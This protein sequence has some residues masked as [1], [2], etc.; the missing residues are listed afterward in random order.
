MKPIPEFVYHTPQDL[1]EALQLISEYVDSLP[2]AGGTDLIIELRNGARKT[3]HL[4]SL[5]QV[6]DLNYIK[7]ESGHIHIGATTKHT[8]IAS[9]KLIKNRASILSEAALQVGSNQIRNLGTVGGNLCNASPGA[10]TATPLLVLGAQAVISSKEGTR[11]VPLTDFF[12]GPKRNCLKHGELLTE[13][14]FPSPPEGSGGG[15]QKLGRRQGCTI[16]LINAAA[17]IEV[18]SGV[19]KEARVAVGACAP[20]PVRIPAV[21]SQLKGEMLDHDLIE[22]VSRACY[23]LVEPSQ[24]EHSRAS[25]EYRR[26]MSCVLMKRALMGALDN[27][28]R[29]MK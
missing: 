13:V 4:I 5:N 27:A 28:R 2:I 3:G 8:Q 22:E 25:E 24:R 6:K 18:E 10:D 20:T 1:S 26:E 11:T 7:E 12:T 29:N 23:V 19:C 9:S 21:E 16:S 15:F 14:S 17:Y